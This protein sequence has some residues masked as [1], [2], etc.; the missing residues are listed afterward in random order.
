PQQTNQNNGVDF[1]VGDVIVSLCNAINP[2]LFEVREL[3]HVTY[4]EFIKCRPIPNGDYFCWLAVNEIRTATPS[5][6]Q[7]NRRLSKTELALAEVS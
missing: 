2:V 1:L 7:A 4:P 6:L 5:E 3:A